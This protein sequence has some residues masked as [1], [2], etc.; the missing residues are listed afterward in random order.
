[1]T[2]SEAL[3]DTRPTFLI[4]RLLMLRELEPFRKGSSSPSTITIG[5]LFPEIFNYDFLGSRWGLELL[6]CFCFFLEFPLGSSWEASSVNSSERLDRAFSSSSSSLIELRLFLM[7]YIEEFLSLAGR[8][9]LWE[10]VSSTIFDEPI[11]SEIVF[12]L[13]DFDVINSFFFFMSKV[14][15]PP[16][17]VWS[18]CRISSCGSFVIIF[19]FIRNFLLAIYCPC[20]ADSLTESVSLRPKKKLILSSYPLTSS[21]SAGFIVVREWA[22]AFDN[23]CITIF[24]LFFSRSA[25]I[26]FMW[27]FFLS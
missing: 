17:T 1:M 8:L 18:M 21:P 7:F 3:V 6:S 25:L 19:C 22:I 20:L 12:F 27:C 14:M 11:G 5:R 24:S 10:P 23:F 13:G 16:V 15:C 4:L 2:S 9:T 26:D